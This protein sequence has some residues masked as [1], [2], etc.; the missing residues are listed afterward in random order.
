MLNQIKRV[1]SVTINLP[2]SQRSSQASRRGSLGVTRLTSWLR[3]QKPEPSP[4]PA[5]RYPLSPHHLPQEFWIFQEPSETM[6]GLLTSLQQYRLLHLYSPSNLQPSASFLQARRHWV[7]SIL[8]LV[9]VAPGSYPTSTIAW[10][11]QSAHHESS[12]AGMT[13]DE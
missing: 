1:I 5:W 11:S 8:Y 2:I 13:P 7:V 9:E 6:T 12:S 10:L 4:I 3:P